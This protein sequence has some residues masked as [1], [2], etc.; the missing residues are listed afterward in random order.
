MERRGLQHHAVSTASAQ[1]E[2]EPAA[3]PEPAYAT[4][5]EPSAA[6]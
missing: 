3:Q 5:P 6:A 1:P 4:E 2:P